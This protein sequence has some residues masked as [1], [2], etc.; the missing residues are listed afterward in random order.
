[1]SADEQTDATMGALG[2][3]VASSDPAAEV[4]PLA[5]DGP[6]VTPAPGGWRRVL[7]GLLVGLVAGALLALVLPRRRPASSPDDRALGVDT[8][9][10][11]PGEDDGT[12]R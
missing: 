11:Y 1:M 3:P 10:P 9:E 4:E 6:L 7:L 2:G 12:D 5:A 8:A